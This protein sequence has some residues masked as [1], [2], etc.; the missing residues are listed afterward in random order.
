MIEKQFINY[1]TVINTSWSHFVY[2]CCLFVKLNVSIYALYLIFPTCRVS[3]F[4]LLAKLHSYKCLLTKKVFIHTYVYVFDDFLANKMFSTVEW[5]MCLTYFLFNLIRHSSWK[6]VTGMRR[7]NFY[8]RRKHIIRL[9][10]VIHII[11]YN[12]L[13]G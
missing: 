2:I 7:V 12:R 3:T 4:E 10:S 8:M 5:K 1:C 13:F 11:H 6:F 9:L